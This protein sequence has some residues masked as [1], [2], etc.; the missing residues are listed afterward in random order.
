MIHRYLSISLFGLFGALLLFSFQNCSQTGFSAEGSAGRDGLQGVAGGPNPGNL[1]T[2]PGADPQTPELGLKGG[3]FDLD[4]SSQVYQFNQGSTDRHIHEYDDKYNVTK[5]D[6]FNLLDSK[7]TQV[8]DRVAAGQTFYII[9]GNAALSPGAILEVN[10]ID[11]GVVE[12]QN[13]VSRFMAGDVAALQQFSLASLQSF[14]LKF[15]KDDLGQGVLVPTQTNCVVNNKPSARNEY[16]N[17]AL[18][19][20]ILDSQ[21]IG[22]SPDTRTALPTGGLLWEASI[23]WHKD[24][25]ACQ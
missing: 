5:V 16:R 24:G 2:P 11:V 6:F 9:V 12:Y 1:V 22:I 7:L 17:G 20:Q 8:S 3:H 21:K 10:G 4:T 18:V 15:A 25:T 19:V 14:R 13:R 23:F